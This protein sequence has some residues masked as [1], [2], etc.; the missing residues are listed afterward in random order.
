MSVIRALAVGMPYAGLTRTTQAGPV[1]DRLIATG[2]IRTPVADVR[3]QEVVELYDETLTGMNRTDMPEFGRHAQVK[4]SSEKDLDETIITWEEH[5]TGEWGGKHNNVGD[6]VTSEELI[7]QNWSFPAIDDTCMFVPAMHHENPDIRSLANACGRS[8]GALGHSTHDMDLRHGPFGMEGRS[9]FPFGMGNS[10]VLVHDEQRQ[11]V[12]AIAKRDDAEIEGDAS[13]PQDAVDLME[14]RS[15]VNVVDQ[16]RLL[17][18]KASP[19]QVSNE[20]LAELFRSPFGET[21]LDGPF[22]RLSMERFDD[23]L[24]NQ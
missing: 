2:V 13:H 1:L 22:S 4:V 18:L 24:T 11:G 17:D 15:P 19:L 8:H 21:S 6:S 12:A 10:E 20:E 16:L 23:S 7:A 5:V 9:L 14:Q 3:S